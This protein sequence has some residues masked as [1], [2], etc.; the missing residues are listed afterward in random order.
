MQCLLLPAEASSRHVVPKRSRRA[1][2]HQSLSGSS[3]KMP[4]QPG[5]LAHVSVNCIGTMS[6]AWNVTLKELMDPMRSPTIIL[7]SQTS[8]P[9]VPH[10][11]FTFRVQGLGQPRAQGRRVMRRRCCWHMRAGRAPGTRASRATTYAAWWAGPG[12]PCC[13]LAALTHH[14]LEA[15]LPALRDSRQGTLS[16]A[17][18]RSTA[19][20]VRLV[21]T[22]TSLRVHEMLV[23]FR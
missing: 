15:L 21:E 3:A 14:D 8:S 1:P 2:T 7:P 6:H 23:V 13:G 22:V 19:K 10:A 12:P 18:L 9:V 16:G 5:L 20:R 4:E 11:Y 17:V